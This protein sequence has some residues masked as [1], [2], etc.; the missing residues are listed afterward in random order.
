MD[1]TGLVRAIEGNAA[2]LLM[3]MGAAGGGSQR[4]DGRVRWTIGG[5]PIDYHNAVVAADLSGEEA[6]EVIADSLQTMKS[7]GVPGCWH[8]GPSMRP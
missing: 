8:V 7:H 6:D 1:E 2:E 5:S 3:R 4:A